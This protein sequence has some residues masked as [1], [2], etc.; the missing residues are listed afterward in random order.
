MFYEQYYVDQAMQKGG[1]LRAFHRARFQ[2]GYG[3]GSTFKG[4]FGWAM[5]HF[6]EG[7]KVMGKK[8]LQ[9]GVNVAEDIPGGIIIKS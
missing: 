8:A 4:L 5:P 1:N 3:L 6:Q 9:T 7:A 2:W